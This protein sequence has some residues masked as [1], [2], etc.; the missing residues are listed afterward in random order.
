ML[1][2]GASLPELGQVLRHRQMATTAIYARI[3]HEG[4]RS[5]ALARPG[6]SA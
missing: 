5:I 2:N 4:L 1:R 6:E 3:D